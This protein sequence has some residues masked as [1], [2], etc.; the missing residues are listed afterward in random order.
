VKDEKREDIYTRVTNQIVT[1]IEHGPGGYRLPWHVS[2]VDSLQPRNVASELPYRGVNVL[3]LW[4]TAQMKEYPSGL[5]GTY[6]QWQELGAQIRKG[7]K[8]TTVVLWKVSEKEDPPVDPEEDGKTKKVILARGYSV[9]NLSQVDGYTPPDTPKLSEAQRT[10]AADRFFFGLAADIRH[11]GDRAFYR[12]S[13][14]YIQMPPYEAFRKAEG[15]YNV[16][17]HELTHWS[18]AQ[19]RLARDLS[20]RFGEDRYAAE[21]LVAELGSAFALAK[22]GISAEPRPDHAAYIANWISLL[23]SDPRAIFT[24]ASKAQ[25]AVDWLT[26]EHDRLL[27][28]KHMPQHEHEVEHEISR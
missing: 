3:C 22:L 8:A 5:W 18:G 24:A 19:H 4:A 16:L 14:D 26:R 25:H 21:E 9:F 10:H 1:A 2:S 27:L 13:A 23:K 17:A 6:K 12:P 15:Y 20:T 28:N 11:G 7:E